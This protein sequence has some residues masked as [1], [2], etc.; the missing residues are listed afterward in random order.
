MAV[1][2]YVNDVEGQRRIDPKVTRPNTQAMVKARWP[3]NPRRTQSSKYS[4]CLY[5]KKFV[6]VCYEVSFQDYALM[7]GRHNERRA[8]RDSM[9]EVQHD[10]DNSD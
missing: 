6:S 4:I 7:E 5:M 2:I 3:V 9:L 10:T 8:R 1:I